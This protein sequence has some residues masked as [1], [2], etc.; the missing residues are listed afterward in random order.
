MSNTT[1]KDGLKQVAANYNL[2]KKKKLYSS[3]LIADEV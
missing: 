1:I 2:D 3:D